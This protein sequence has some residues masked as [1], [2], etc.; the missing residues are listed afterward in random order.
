MNT[1]H[2]ES[3][4]KLFRGLIRSRD[5]DTLNGLRAQYCLPGEFN[6]TCLRWL[7]EV[8]EEPGMLRLASGLPE[9]ESEDEDDGNNDEQLKLFDL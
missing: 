9:W 7:K 3:I 1:N 5:F 6:E 2:E 8:E 4:K